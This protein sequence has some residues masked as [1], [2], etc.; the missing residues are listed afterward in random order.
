MKCSQRLSLLLLCALTA[1]VANR[2][3]PGPA[4][5]PLAPARPSATVA[6]PVPVATSTATSLPT[7]SPTPPELPPV[8]QTNRLNP[9]DTPHTY[10]TD[11]C[12]YLRD[13]WQSGHS[14]PGTVVMVI[15]FHSIGAATV[16]NQIS[17]T[18]FHALM[19]ALQNHGFTAITT[20]QLADF[21]EHN[22]F[23]PPR[24]V[25]LLVDDR[26]YRQYFDTYFRPYYERYGWPVVNAWISTPQNTEALW[27]QQVDLEREGWV[28]H[29]AH[30]VIHNFPITEA[31]TDDF[32]LS[33]LQGSVDA[34]LKYFGKRPLAYIWPLGG[35][36]RRAAELARQTG[37]RLGFTIN[38]RGPLMFNW[39]PLADAVDPQRP[40]YLPEGGVNDPLMVLPRY[41]ATDAISHLDNVQQIGQ[42]AAAYAAQNKAIELAYY[43]SACEPLYGPLP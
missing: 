42:E 2:S 39:V 43:A 6:S 41:W 18:D 28:D 23:I 9:L 36:S 22:A 24:A 37:Y 26:R 32:I 12:A 19:Q 29:Q 31:S 34:F 3:A 8:F 27:Q 20:T 25:L 14:A 11:P 40:S 33:E 7:S 16:G 1:C 10:L 38:P 4:S 5:S 21:L 35:F 17:E 15:M 30:G 13:K